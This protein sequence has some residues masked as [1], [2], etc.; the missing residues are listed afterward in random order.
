[1]AKRILKTRTQFTST[2]ENEL[3]K[4]LQRVSKETKVPMS[5][6]LDESVLYLL[7]ARTGNKQSNKG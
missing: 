6:L 5:R 4:S 2:L 7:E 1:M 3:Y